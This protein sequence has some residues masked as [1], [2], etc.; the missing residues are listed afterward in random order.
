[1]KHANIIALLS[2]I[3]VSINFVAI[4]LTSIFCP[5]WIPIVLSAILICLNAHYECFA[6]KGFLIQKETIA[7]KSL[8]LVSYN[9]NLAYKELSSEDK[10]QKIA[11]F[12][13]K[14]DAD[15]VLLQEYNPLIF[16]VVQ[17]ELEKMF[18]YGS[19][20]KLADRYKAVYSKYPISDYIQLKDEWNYGKKVEGGEDKGYL[21]ICGMTVSFDSY[22][23]CVVNCHLHS[24]N[25]SIALRKLKHKEVSLFCFFKEAIN[26]LSQGIE[27]RKRQTRLLAEYVRGINRPLL[28]CGDMNDVSGSSIMKKF[29]SKMLKDAWWQKGRG[30]GFTFA[31]K[32]M[33]WRLDH[34]LYSDGIKIDSMKV[35]RSKM[36]DHR[37]IICKFHFNKYKVEYEGNI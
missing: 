27:G 36:S 24:N 31:T 21:P 20:F 16:P 14:E 15:L 30:F 2:P 4:A 29:T 11:D 18:R 25:F 12:L 13:L 37:P 8:T 6:Y 23:L 33:R 34:I 5:L 10:A 35:G 22:D 28:I 32:G 26:L 7:P 17:H 1:M 9:V 19:P 3:L